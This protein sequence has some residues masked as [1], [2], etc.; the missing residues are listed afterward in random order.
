MFNGTKWKGNTL[1]YLVVCIQL[2]IRVECAK[3]SYLELIKQEK[4]EKE[5][6][7]KEKGDKEAGDATKTEESETRIDPPSGIPNTLLIRKSK[8]KFFVTSLNP[9]YKDEDGNVLSMETEGNA[10][11]S[12]GSSVPEN[13]SAPSQSSNSQVVSTHK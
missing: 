12:D 4:E 8:R 6:K 1:K 10:K 3:P 2:I 13:V 7:E 9:I 11:E 5:E